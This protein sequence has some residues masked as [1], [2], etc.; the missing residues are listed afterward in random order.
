MGHTLFFHKL[1][2]SFSPVSHYHSPR[3]SRIHTMTTRFRTK[4]L[5]NP[6]F[7]NIHVL[8]QNVWA[9]N[10]QQLTTRI[11][12]NMCNYVTESQKGKK[13]AAPKHTGTGTLRLLNIQIS[14]V[15][16]YRLSCG[17]IRRHRRE[18]L[19]RFRRVSW[20]FCSLRHQTMTDSRVLSATCPFKC[21]LHS[22]WFVESGMGS[23]RN[24]LLG[25]AMSSATH[26]DYCGHP[27]INK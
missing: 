9:W 25:I 22:T 3:G 14:P 1:R 24:Y 13:R 8:D 27:V 5:D 7:T 6:L 4:R 19:A 17:R 23:T 16:H 20:L 21:F 26:V 2:V 11:S 18:R 15:I 12:V 10:I